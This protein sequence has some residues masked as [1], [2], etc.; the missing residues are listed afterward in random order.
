[1]PLKLSGFGLIEAVGEGVS[2]SRGQKKEIL[3]SDLGTRSA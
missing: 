2:V 1:M 3:G